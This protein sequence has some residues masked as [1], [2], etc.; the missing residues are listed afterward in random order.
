MRA[1][2]DLSFPALAALVDE[3]L[4]ALDLEDVALSATIPAATA[5]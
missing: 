2:A 3:F 5:S 4:A 1:D